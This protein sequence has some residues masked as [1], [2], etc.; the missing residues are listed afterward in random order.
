MS[1]CRAP[2]IAGLCYAIALC[3]PGLAD[4]APHAIA[5]TP[6]TVA[7]YATVLRHYNPQLPDWQSKDLARHLLTTAEHWKIDA[8]MLAAIVTVES[9]WHTHALSSAGAIGLGQ[10]MPGTAATLGV[11]PRDPAS[12]LAGAAQYLRGLMQ[13][14]STHPNRYALVF[15]A[16]NAGPKA[17]K[18]F[19]GIPPFEETQ[20]Y[21]VKVLST[22]HHLQASIHVPKT[23]L[24]NAG[25]IAASGPD[26]DYWLN[27]ERR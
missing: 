7:V 14:F 11:N 9:S 15:A 20:R 5:A 21:V 4:A 1:R 17:V 26:V 24:A 10:L 16:Y 23:V 27:A 6:T 13:T 3:F 22:W 18:E 25:K 12:N 8:N 2:L 19:G